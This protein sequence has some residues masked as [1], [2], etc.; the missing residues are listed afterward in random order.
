M[1]SPR[2]RRLTLA[3]LAGI[4]LE[5]GAGPAA[6]AGLTTTYCGQVKQYQPPASANPPSGSIT[7]GAQTIPLGFGSAATTNVGA[8]IC[9]TGTYNS[10]GVLTDY[11]VAA[12]PTTYCGNVVGFVAPTGSTNGHISL[13]SANTIATFKI[14]A[15]ATVSAGDAQGDR[16]AALAIDASG[17]AAVRR[18]VAAAT[19]S[20][21]PSTSSNPQSSP[22]VP[23]AVLAMIVLIAA[24][25][26]WR[27]ALTRR[28]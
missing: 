18:L 16:C 13:A 7:I 19:P 2:W 14:P 15:A 1:T 9:L 17:D 12:M 11:A 4:A 28:R 20:A 26:L 5:L 25:T 8:T 23:P 21:L 22:F 10:Q 6:A 3:A 27:G 24:G